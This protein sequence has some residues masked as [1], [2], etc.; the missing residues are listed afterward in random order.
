MYV[1]FSTQKNIFNINQLEAD[2]VQL[3]VLHK[4]NI[5]KI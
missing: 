1:L 2:N 5:L 4:E 3:N